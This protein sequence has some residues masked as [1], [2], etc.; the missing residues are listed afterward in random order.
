MGTTTKKTITAKVTTARI[1]SDGQA[2]VEV[3]FNSGKIEW[4]KT[5]S[6]FTTQIIKESD[7]KARIAADIGKDLKSQD[8][9]KEIVP[10]IGKPFTFEV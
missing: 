3:A 10:L 6:Y 5:Y 4:S 2:T 9:L 8:Q 1:D 7:L